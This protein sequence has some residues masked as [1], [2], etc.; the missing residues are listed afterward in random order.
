MA[1]TH[2]IQRAPHPRAHLIH[3]RGRRL[4]HLAWLGIVSLLIFK[5]VEWIHQMEVPEGSH[6]ATDLLGPLLIAL[7][8]YGVVTLVMMILDLMAVETDE[9]QRFFARAQKGY[10]TL[11]HPH[12]HFTIPTALFVV[13][14]IILT[15][16]M[17]VRPLLHYGL[18]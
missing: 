12:R 5:H 15:I 1:Q 7:L 18:F 14:G 8:V 4:F 17:I 3:R 11:E 2:Q 9:S 16:F 13:A 6:D 10:G